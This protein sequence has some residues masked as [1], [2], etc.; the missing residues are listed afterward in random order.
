MN[1]IICDSC[2]QEIKP[3]IEKKFLDKGIVI[4]FFR[5][6]CSEKYLI[7]VTDKEIREK[8]QEH[9]EMIKAINLLLDIDISKMDDEEKAKAI[10]TTAKLQD[11]AKQLLNEI[12]E[13]KAEL[14]E[15][16]EGEL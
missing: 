7:D 15:R 5:C 12:K 2:K 10:A 3:K 4:Q 6:K 13:A 11:N 14:K 8:Q 16:Y 1:K 9:A